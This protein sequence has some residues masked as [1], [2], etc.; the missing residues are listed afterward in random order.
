VIGVGNP[1][2]RDDGAGLV[3]ARRLHGTVPAG[4]AVLEHEG[5]PT[6][7]VDRW[8]GAD[9][10]WLVDAVSSGAAPGTVH[11]LDASEAPLPAA[12]FRASSHLVSV[13]EAV[14]LARA[15][16]RLPARVVVLGIE[17]TRFEA[18]EGLSAEVATA[19]D[20]VV[21]ALREELAGQPTPGAEECGP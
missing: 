19:V 17:G 10:V 5:E 21:D 6:A 2:R 9:A 11:R 13:A 20:R 7:L 15:L 16:D 14:E 4:V 1:W 18:G 12:L 8:E 3:A